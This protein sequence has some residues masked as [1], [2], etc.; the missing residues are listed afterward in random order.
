MQ[1][2]QKY[3]KM[4]GIAAAV[5]FMMAVSAIIYRQTAGKESKMQRDLELAAQYLNELDYEQAIAIYSS[6]LEIESNNTDALMGLAQA[7][8]GKAEEGTA[9]AEMRLEY[10]ELAIAYAER[11]QSY[12]GENT[13]VEERLLQTC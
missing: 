11:A 13:A 2:R 10:F 4:I 8:T 6:V 3:Y 12:A 9:T 7:Y 5:L 1:D